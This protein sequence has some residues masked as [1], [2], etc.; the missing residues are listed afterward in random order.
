MLKILLWRW[1]MWF[2]STF[3][4]SMLEPWEKI[5]IGESLALS[6]L[7]RSC[8]FVANFCYFLPP[9]SIAGQFSHDPP[10]HFVFLDFGHCQA[11][12]SPRHDYETTRDVLPCRTGRR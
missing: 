11:P 2:E 7:L 8:S 10:H 12:S 1:R 3:V 6:F 9:L 4:L 5:L